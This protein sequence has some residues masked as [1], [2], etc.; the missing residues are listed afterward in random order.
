M[1]II[2]LSD[3]QA[4]LNKVTDDTAFNTALQ[5]IVDKVNN[6]VSIHLIK[7]ITAQDRTEYCDG[8]GKYLK[9]SVPLV[10]SITKIE[11]LVDNEFVELVEG[12]DYTRIVEA[13]GLIKFEGYTIIEGDK[14]YRITYNGGYATT[15]QDYK[16]IKDACLD[17]LEIYFQQSS[18]GAGTLGVKSVA[19]NKQGFS[20][21]TVFDKEV[22]NKILNSISRYR[23]TNV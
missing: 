3:A 21:N 7:D 5:T 13:Y 14:N 10:N 2:T 11:A 4:R 15:S 17:L 19:N 9:V 23:L 20:E 6:K 22:E 8:N 12:V 18:L 16:Y 1:N